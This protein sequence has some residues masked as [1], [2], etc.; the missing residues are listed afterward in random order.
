VEMVKKMDLS[1][2]SHLEVAVRAVE[3]VGYAGEGADGPKCVDRGPFRFFSLFFSFYL[4]P[5]ISRIQI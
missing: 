2:G 4:F 3:Q 1:S 5:L